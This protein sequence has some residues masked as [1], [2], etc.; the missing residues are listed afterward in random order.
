VG[1]AFNHIAP[2]GVFAACRQ[3]REGP[4]ARTLVELLTPLAS[5]RGY[6]SPAE[7]VPNFRRMFRHP[8]QD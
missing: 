1:S 7:V 4:P 6:A 2:R 3:R 8:E 5:I